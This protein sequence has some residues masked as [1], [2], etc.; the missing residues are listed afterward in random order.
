MR[1][2]CYTKFA[3]SS[4][5]ELLVGIVCFHDPIKQGSVRGKVTSKSELA[6][7]FVQR[8]NRAFPS[9]EYR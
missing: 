7:R 4:R 8:T 5:L 3:T 6:S 1:Y 2:R 9:P